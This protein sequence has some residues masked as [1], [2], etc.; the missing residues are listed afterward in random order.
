MQQ[1]RFTVINEAFNCEVCGHQNLPAAQTCRDHCVKCLCSK[2]VDKNPGDRAETCH[3][4]LEPFDVK[5]IGGQISQIIYKCKKCQKLRN[6]KIMDDDNRD[7]LYDLMVK[8]A[9]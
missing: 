9:F 5:I 4:I 7:I 8:K 6:N 1:K 2:H 3:G